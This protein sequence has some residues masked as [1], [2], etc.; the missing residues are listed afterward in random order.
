MRRRHG[1]SFIDVVLAMVIV[2]LGTLGATQFFSSVYTDLSPQGTGGGLRRY[3]LAEGML[4]AEAEAL[5]A[6]RFTW[7]DNTTG[8]VKMIT[9]APGAGFTLTIGMPPAQTTALT[10]F[11]Y[12]DLAVTDASGN[13]LGQLSLS[14]LRA[15]SG[16]LDAKIGL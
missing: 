7:P 1:F 8:K 16:G 12:Y 6:T 11:L 13:T 5:R 2:A 15:F 9:E 14:T 3:L 4:K 10:Q